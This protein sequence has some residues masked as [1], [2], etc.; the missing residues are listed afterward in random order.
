MRITWCWALLAVAAAP[1]AA[2]QN[3]N[4]FLVSSFAIRRCA[5]ASIPH[6]GRSRPQVRGEAFNILNRVNLATPVAT[7]TV[8]TSARSPPTSAVRRL[9]DWWP[10]QAA[11]KLSNSP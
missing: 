1:L 7:V 3:T 5:G 4:G 2:Q 6:S 8:P 11:R 9:A 10:L